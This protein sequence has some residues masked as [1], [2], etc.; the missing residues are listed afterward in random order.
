M[1]NCSEVA[2]WKYMDFAKFAYLVTTRSLHF[3]CPSRFQDPYEGLLPRSHIEAESKML[4]RYVDDMIALRP[5]FAEQSKIS[6]ELFDN[7]LEKFAREVRGAHEEAAAAFGVCCWHK[8]EYESAAMWRLYSASGQGIAI[9]STIGRLKASLGDTA[10]L[11]IDS[12]RYMDFDEDPIE[13]GHKHYALFIKR[14]C[15]EYEKELRATVL[16]PVK[17]E[18]IS[19]PCDLGVLIKA[20]HVSP[21]VEEYVTRAV[22]N[23]CAG[24]VHSLRVPVL[25]SKLFDRPDYGIDVDVKAAAV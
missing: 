4:R 5:A 7:I 19:L 16:L 18:G 20:I 12:V 11:Q 23:L 17:G 21:L 15:F 22:E 1:D 24:K 8:S 2:I 3:A 6:L 9:E 13:K 10:G 25:Q 14:K